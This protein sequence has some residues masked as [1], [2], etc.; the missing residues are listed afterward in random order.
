[1][2]RPAL[3]LQLLNHLSLLLDLRPQ[4]RDL[5]LCLAKVVAV[6]WLDFVLQLHVSIS[7]FP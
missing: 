4:L 7:I 2:V 3:L 1:M 6:I 5:T